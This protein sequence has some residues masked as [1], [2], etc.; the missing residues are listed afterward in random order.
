MGIIGKTIARPVI[1]TGITYAIGRIFVQHFATGV[2]WLR[3]TEA[4]TT[5]LSLLPNK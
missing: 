1:A 4:S 5:N 3:K 2:V